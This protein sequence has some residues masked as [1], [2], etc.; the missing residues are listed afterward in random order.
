MGTPDSNRMLVRVIEPRGDKHIRV[1]LG[2]GMGLIDGALEQ[3]WTIDRI[4]EDL[5][6]P[7]TEFWLVFDDTH[8]ELRVERKTDE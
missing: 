8:G 4:P 7:H 2:P 3:D 1:M 5:R 6:K